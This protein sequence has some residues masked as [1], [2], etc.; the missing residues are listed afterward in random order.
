M[1][2]NFQLLFFSELCFENRNQSYIQY[3]LV[4]NGIFLIF[5]K[6]HAL[7]IKCITE[8]ANTQFSP[9]KMAFVIP[10]P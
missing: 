2:G 5:F 6:G 10:R 7:T 9:V 4:F 1:K 3:F 8:F